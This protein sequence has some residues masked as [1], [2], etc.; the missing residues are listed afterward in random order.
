M[1]HIEYNFIE[2]T[3]SGSSTTVREGGA[4]DR[5]DAHV[6]SCDE[7]GPAPAAAWPAQCGESEQP[8]DEER[9]LRRPSARICQG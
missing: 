1:I 3:L 7:N 5:A 4:A 6:D 8:E 9:R 2:F